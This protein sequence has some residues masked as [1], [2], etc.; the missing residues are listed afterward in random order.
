[1]TEESSGPVTVGQAMK[2]LSGAYV[3]ALMAQVYDTTPLFTRLAAVS[4]PRN[5]QPIYGPP[6]PRV[7]GFAAEFTIQNGKL[8]IDGYED[9]EYPTR[10]HVQE[11][12]DFLQWALDNDL[13]RDGEGIW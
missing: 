5:Y 9:S 4:P 2:A 13:V 1:M 6:V 12:I 10:G 7:E 8:H 3:P 11:I